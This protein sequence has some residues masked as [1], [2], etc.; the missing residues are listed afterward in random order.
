V[1]VPSGSIKDAF[2][3]VKGYEGKRAIDA[4]NGFGGRDESFP[5]LAH[6]VQSIT[7]GPVAKAFNVNFSTAYD[8]VG[9]QRVR[10]GNLWCGD[11][12]LREVTEQLIRDAGYEPLAAGGL[13][14][15]RALEDF[16]M[17]FA[18]ASES[19]GGPLMYRFAKPGEL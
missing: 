14:N 5:S 18:A 6:E 3:K 9:S 19:A 11:E 8:E 12:D 4:T 2:G 13:S 17:P 7:G 15:A 16:V 10:P 1:A